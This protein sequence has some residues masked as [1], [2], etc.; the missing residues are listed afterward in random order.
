MGGECADCVLGDLE[1]VFC[2]GEDWGVEGVDGAR[3]S[4]LLQGFV[5]PWW[6]GNVRYGAGVGLILMGSDPAVVG[7]V[8]AGAQQTGPRVESE[9]G[10]GLLAGAV[11]SFEEFHLRGV[12]RQV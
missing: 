11:L 6:G 7:V 4:G 5:G 2:G 9:E 12:G 3:A 10:L 8:G 1:R